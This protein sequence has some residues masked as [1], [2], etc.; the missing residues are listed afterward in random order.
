MTNTIILHTAADTDR[1]VWL[2]QAWRSRACSASRAE[3]GARLSFGKRMI[4]VGLWSPA[5]VEG[6]DAS[7]LLRAIAAHGRRG[8]LI[9]WDLP[10]PPATLVA[11]R[12]PIILASGARGEDI[13]KLDQ[14]AARIEKGRVVVSEHAEKAERS[15]S[16]ERPAPRRSSW[17]Q[18]RR[19]EL[20]AHRLRDARPI[21]PV[22]M[23]R[24]RRLGYVI[25][26]VLGLI[27]LIGA[28]GPWAASLATRQ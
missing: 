12:V 17:R 8:F 3:A 25:G 13:S 21:D 23:R 22:S 19:A 28:L 27:V 15:F 5:T 11:A 1:A 4:L 20:A 24:A 26:A 14:I 6:P 2:V 18:R 10:Q 16:I 7:A 9:L